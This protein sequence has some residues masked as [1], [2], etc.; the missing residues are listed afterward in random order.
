MSMLDLAAL[1]STPLRRYPFA[2]VIIPGFF[3]PE[4]LALVHADYP[5]ID[6]PGS[7]PITELSFGP[8]FRSL[9]EELRAPA[10]RAVF[11]A[12]FGLDLRGRPTMV[13]VRGRCGP[14]D[15]KI[16]TDSASKLITALIYMNPRWEEAGGQLRLLRSA[17][18]LEGVVVEGPPLEGTLVAFRRRNNSFHGHR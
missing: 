5:R 14:R 13:T 4:A 9:V 7:F 12:K 16:H 3:R 18:D 2:Y 17:D 1:R 6:S 8:A 10:A 15:G 11:A